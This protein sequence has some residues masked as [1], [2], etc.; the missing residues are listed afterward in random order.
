MAVINTRDED[1]K[2]GDVIDRGSGVGGKF[3]YRIILM[4]GVICYRIKSF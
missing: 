1:L 4:L 2:V 3:S